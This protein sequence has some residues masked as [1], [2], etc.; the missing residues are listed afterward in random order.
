MAKQADVYADLATSAAAVATV[1]NL[2][3]AIGDNNFEPPVD[4]NGMILPYLRFDFM[5]NAPFWEGI[6][7]GRL[8]QGMMQITLTMPRPHLVATALGLVDDII[9]LYPKAVRLPGAGR[10]KVQSSPWV[11]SPIVEGDRTYYPVTV[12]WVC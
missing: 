9:T 6:R 4:G 1:L 11:A 12:P 2:P 8:D 5:N 3:P 10:V 7:T